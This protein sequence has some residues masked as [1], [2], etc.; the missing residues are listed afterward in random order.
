MSC[1]ACFSGHVHEGQP[2]GRVETIHGRPTYIA[3]PEEGKQ[4]KGIIIIVPDVFGWEFVNTRILAD[5]YSAGGDY[6]VYLIDF[7]DGWAAPVSTMESMP[8]L[9][10]NDSIWDWVWKPYY[11]AQGLSSFISVATFN[12]YS[13]A[14]PRVHSFFEAVRKNEGAKLGIGAAGFCWGG[15][16]VVN[17]THEESFVD[18]VPLVDASFTGHPGLIKIPGDLEKIR[19]PVSLAIGDNDYLLSV[20]Q[21]EGVKEIFGNNPSVPTEVTAEEQAL[22]W[23]SRHL[24]AVKY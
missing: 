10:K 16:Y 3:E 6:L 23:F 5:H 13:V 21:I 15:R 1:P 9:M 17:L 11:A 12:R 4:P 19:K 24:S 22:E 18:G 7:M 20:H 8:L 2:K 14:W